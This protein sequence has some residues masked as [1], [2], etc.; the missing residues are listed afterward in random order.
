MKKLCLVALLA[1]GFLSAPAAHAVQFLKCNSEGGK[2]IYVTFGKVFRSGDAGPRY[3]PIE[4]VIFRSPQELQDRIFF[5]SFKDTKG[6]VVESNAAA[7]QMAF[8][9]KGVD[10]QIRT[11]A[12]R[13]RLHSPQDLHGFVGEW[14]TGKESLETKQRAFC[15]LF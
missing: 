15:S 2:T 1:L 5:G 9:A 12:L 10:G 11:E 13:L 3:F 6:I 14:A 8:P 7:F 4:I